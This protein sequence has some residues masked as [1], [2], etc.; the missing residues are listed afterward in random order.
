L[1]GFCQAGWM[2]TERGGFL[3]VEPGGEG[4]RRANRRDSPRD[5]TRESIDSAHHRLSASG[6]HPWGGIAGC[7]HVVTITIARPVLKPGS[8]RT[9]GCNKEV[10]CEISK[11]QPKHFRT[12]P[13]AGTRR[14]SMCWRFC[15]EPKKT[16]VLILEAGN[17]RRRGLFSIHSGPHKETGLSSRYLPGPNVYVAGWNS[18][19]LRVTPASCLAWTTRM[20]RPHSVGLV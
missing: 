20:V 18:R 7:V 12:V 13:A 9:L 5:G 16:A 2:L 3:L 19:P 6:G 4:I 17:T 10:Q 15:P 1:I 8:C 11:A 14:V